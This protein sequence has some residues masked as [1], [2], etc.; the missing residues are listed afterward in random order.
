MKKKKILLVWLL[1]FSSGTILAQG[2]LPQLFLFV[3]GNEASSYRH[4]LKNNCINGIQIIYSWK[5]LE[6]KKGFYDF[7]KIEKDLKFLDK[8]QK[9]LFIQIQ[10]RSFTPDVF[11]VPDYIRKESIYHGGVEMQYDF[12]GEGKPITTG[13]VARTWDS[14]VRKRFQLLIRK[15]ASQFDG[16]VYGINLPE[17]SADFDPN[18]MPKD[19]TSDKYFYSVI[20]NI[21]YLK[22]SFKKSKVI[23]YV[24][25]FPEEWNDDH[26]YMSRLFAFAMKHHIGLG[27][28]D[29]V[30]Y[31]DSQMNNSYPFFHKYNGKIVTALA[32]QEPDYTYKNPKT[33]D[34]YN[35][36]DFYFFSKEYLGTSI[37][38]WN[39]EEPFLSNQ[40]LP[41]LNVNYFMC[42]QDK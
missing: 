5:Q 34:F 11:N 15:L 36:Y 4:I 28:P 8:E 21:H 2:S 29:V 38:F 19:F 6:P 25:F 13:W 33:G 16:R 12:P 30:P 17:T 31:K 41:H 9:K 23:Q 26:L 20:N 24:N 37:L 7:S 39:V 10:D 42:N 27:G 18:H 35:F 1:S 22:K 14:A 32:V 40:L 3:G